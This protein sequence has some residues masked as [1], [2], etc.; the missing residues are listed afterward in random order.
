MRSK[1]NSNTLSTYLFSS[2]KGIVE[3]EKATH[4]L[5]YSNH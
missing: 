2:G 5:K 4:Q 3:G 1:K